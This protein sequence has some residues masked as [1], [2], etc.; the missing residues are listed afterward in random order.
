MMS[1]ITPV[2]LISLKQLFL[3]RKIIPAAMIVCYV[4]TVEVYHDKVEGEE[5]V[6]GSDIG[7]GQTARLD[8]G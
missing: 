7:V 6:T 4:V 2:V 1:R 8:T 3:V 5:D